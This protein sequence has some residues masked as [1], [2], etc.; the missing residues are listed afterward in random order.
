ML[1]CGPYS[2]AL[3][4]PWVGFLGSI[5]EVNLR[6]AVF[7]SS[8]NTSLKEKEGGIF[9]PTKVQ[10]SQKKSNERLFKKIKLSFE[11]VS[12]EQVSVEGN[13]I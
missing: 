12:W 1:D 5:P 13:Q 7:T 9:L 8:G 3:E 2:L 11:Y 10:G 6:V 4:E